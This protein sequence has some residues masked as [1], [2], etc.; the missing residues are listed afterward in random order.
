V[1]FCADCHAIVADD[2]DSLYFMP[3]EL[4]ANSG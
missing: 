2:Q 3:E 1:Q 4:R